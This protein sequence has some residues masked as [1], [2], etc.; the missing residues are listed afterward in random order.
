MISNTYAARY[1]PKEENCKGFHFTKSALGAGSTKRRSGTMN[2]SLTIVVGL[3]K[4]LNGT[5]LCPRNIPKR[6]SS[7]FN[8]FEALRLKR[9]AESGGGLVTAQEKEC[10][11]CGVRIETELSGLT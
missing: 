7:P 8:S 5:R 9:N 4:M 10:W 3:P 2:T 11:L 6:V 1:A